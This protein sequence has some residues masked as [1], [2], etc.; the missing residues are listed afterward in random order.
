[1]DDAAPSVP[2][3]APV[4]PLPPP[5][6]PLT[7]PSPPVPPSRALPPFAAAPPPPASGMGWRMG[8]ALGLIAFLVGVGVAAFVLTKFGRNGVAKPVAT[9]TLPIGA[10]GQAPVVI[11]PGKTGVPVPTIDLAAL[12]TRQTELAAKLA[13]L[14]TRSGVIDRDSQRASAYATRSEGLLVAFAS[15]RALD[16]GLNL[17]FLEEQLRDR[18]GA[19]QP[20]A[21]ATV[22]QAAR[23]PVTLEDLGAGLDGIAPELMTGVASIGWWQSF[24]SEIGNLIVLRRAGTPSP[25][26]VDRVAR[27]RRL[28]EA[29]QV[30]AALSEVSRTPGAAQAGSWTAAAR[31]YIGARR[32]LDVIER[33]AILAPG[34]DAPGVDAVP[35]APAIAP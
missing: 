19:S 28:V 31:R 8:V 9:V 14:E 27:A 33:A 4:L 24:R 17:G 26:P 20:I 10:N 32:A 34:V 35:A 23:A 12:S 29:G 5:V 6:P 22:L 11:V 21:V 1:M 13:D 15:R 7:V 18:F 2:E 16:R 3:L 25:L 30:E